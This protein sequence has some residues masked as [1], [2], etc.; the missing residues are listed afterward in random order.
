MSNLD[1]AKDHLHNIAMKE[2]AAGDKFIALVQDFGGVTLDQANGIFEFMRR[3]KMIKYDGGI[4][5]Y[6]VKHGQYLDREFLEH[7]AIHGAF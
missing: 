5:K 7:L 1:Y 3:H 6:S 4:G 2:F